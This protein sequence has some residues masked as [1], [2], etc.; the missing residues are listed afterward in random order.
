MQVSEKRDRQAVPGT[1]HNGTSDTA[2]R[3]MNPFFE[4]VTA[5]IQNEIFNRSLGIEIAM[6]QKEEL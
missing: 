4:T 3:D 5:S 2:S 6:I 1:R